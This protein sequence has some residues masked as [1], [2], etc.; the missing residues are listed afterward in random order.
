MRS[1]A[2]VKEGICQSLSGWSNGSML[3]LEDAQRE[4]NRAFRWACARGHLIVAQW[5]AD[6]FALTVEDARAKDNAAFRWACEQGHLDVVQ[7]LAERFALTTEDARVMDNSALGWSCAKGHLQ[8]ARW[9]VAQ[10]QLTVEDACAC[11]NIV[12][13]VFHDASRAVGVEWFRKQFAIDA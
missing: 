3:T 8:V 11:R 1:G 2:H 9:L 5:L 10:F 12:F 7:W 4:H 13:H 6:Q